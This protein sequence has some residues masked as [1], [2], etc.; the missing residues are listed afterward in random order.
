MAGAEVAPTDP[1]VDELDLVIF[2]FAEVKQRYPILMKTAAEM[3]QLRKHGDVRPTPNLAAIQVMRDCF[4]ML[5]I[6]LYSIRERLTKKDGI[7]D[8]LKRAP[9]Q[10]S[11]TPSIVRNV[12]LAE[13]VT[14]QIQEAAGRLNASAPPSLE[15]IEALCARFRADTQAPITIEIGSGLTGISREATRPICSSTCLIFRRRSMCLSDIS[16]TSTSS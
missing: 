6:D 11:A 12:D 9:E 13:M 1:L 3:E 2:F 8:L 5:V 16:P 14:R 7:F 15:T 4:D 10:L